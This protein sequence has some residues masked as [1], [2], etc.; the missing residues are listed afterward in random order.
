MIKMNWTTRVARELT[1][2]SLLAVA[3]FLNGC[4]QNATV[5][6]SPSSPPTP[7]SSAPAPSSPAATTVVTSTAAPKFVTGLNDPSGGHP[8]PKLPTLKLW[9]GTNEVTA[10]LAATDQQIAIGMM[11][12]TNMAEMD[13]MLFLFA[14]PGQRAFYMRNTIVPLSCAYIDPEGTILEIHDMKPLDETPIPST[15]DQVQSVL[16]MNQ[17]WFE[18]HGI[19]TGVAVS[20][21]RGTF[22]QTFRRR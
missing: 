14:R 19:K 22:P 4:T 17:G 16:E 7:A 12:R 11:R 13:G 20:T 15:S 2:A 5:V 3:L 10:E 8:Q 18:R 6:S 9:V 1:G 21:E